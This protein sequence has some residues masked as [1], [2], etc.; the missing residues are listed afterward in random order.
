MD[1]PRVQCPGDN[2]NGCPRWL[3][4]GASYCPTCGRIFCGTELMELLVERYGW[5][6]AELES[7]DT[8][9]S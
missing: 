4:I 2:G 1:E 3:R 6:E 5:M 8:A 7:L 9:G